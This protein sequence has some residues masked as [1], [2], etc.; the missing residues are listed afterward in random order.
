ML[1]FYHQGFKVEREE[2]KNGE[3]DYRKIFFSPAF[4]PPSNLNDTKKSPSKKKGVVYVYS[5]VQIFLFIRTNDTNIF[6]SYN[7]SDHKQKI[8]QRYRKQKQNLK[9]KICTD[10]TFNIRKPRDMKARS[11]LE[12]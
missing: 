9:A 3:H 11:V 4:Y 10:G 5:S 8:I 2:E 6:P 1:F 7:I 12:E